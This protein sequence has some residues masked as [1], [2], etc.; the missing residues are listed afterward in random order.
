MRQSRK[1]LNLHGFRE[2]ESPPLRHAFSHRAFCHYFA[3]LVIRCRTSMP[4]SRFLPNIALAALFATAFTSALAQWPDYPT[5]GVPK[6]ADG[7]PNLTG[8]VPRTA[9]NH[10]DLS[11]I[12]DYYR[13]RR[14]EP[15]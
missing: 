5:P 7:K 10:P 8:P 1:L 11:G 2:F 14:L 13:D 3:P 9:D 6:T 15:A 4:K 12:W